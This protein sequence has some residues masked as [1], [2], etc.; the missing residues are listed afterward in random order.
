MKIKK[1]HIENYKSLK[2]VDF[3]LNEGINIFIG[4]NNSGKSNLIDALLF[5]SA[6]MESNVNSAMSNYGGYKELVFSK[7]EWSNIIFEI[8]FTLSQNE[9][10]SWFSNLKL[11]PEITLD[12]FTG[13]VSKEIT[14]QITLEENRTSNDTLKIKLDGNDTLYAEGKMNEGIYTHHALHSFK[15]LR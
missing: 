13:K 7:F 11:E 5:L 1:L 14:Y 10:S 9:M 4:K 3:E 12:D 15:D 6:L 2:M 8:V